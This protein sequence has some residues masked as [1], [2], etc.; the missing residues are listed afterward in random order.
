MPSL[1]RRFWLLLPRSFC[2]WPVLLPPVSIYV[3]V[4]ATPVT[5]GDGHD[6]RVGN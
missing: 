5:W 1:Q 4:V 2:A 6:V 3:V